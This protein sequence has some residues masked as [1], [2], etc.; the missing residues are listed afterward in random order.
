MAEMSLSITFFVLTMTASLLQKELL[1]RA[2]EMETKNKE[3]VSA[4]NMPNHLE[5]WRFHYDLVCQYIKQINRCFGL[6]L[7]I[8]AVLAFAIP[9]FELNKIMQSQ[10]QTGL[11]LPRYYFNFIHTIVTF[12]LEIVMPSYLISRQV[13]RIRRNILFLF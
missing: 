4:E 6:V 13:V 2:E 12:L 1:Q 11:L 7:L 3:E 8:K 5:M 9:I 10:A